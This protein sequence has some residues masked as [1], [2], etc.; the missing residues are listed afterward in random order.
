MASTGRAS[1]RMGGG[2][3]AP[4]TTA[5]AGLGP[6]EPRGYLTAHILKHASRHSPGGPEGISLITSTG[7]VQ[8]SVIAS[9]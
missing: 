6:S 9:D 4:T 3:P 7:F 1:R 8:R 2:W 5:R